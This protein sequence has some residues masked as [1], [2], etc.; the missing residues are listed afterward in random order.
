MKGDRAQP[1]GLFPAK[2]PLFQFIKI[3]RF[4]LGKFSGRSERV[5]ATTS[6]G[7]SQRNQTTVRMALDAGRIAR[8][9]PQPQPR[10]QLTH[11]SSVHH[12]KYDVCADINKCA[13]GAARPVGHDPKHHKGKSR[14]SGKL[15]RISFH[16]CY[17]TNGYSLNLRAF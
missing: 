14:Q 1:S 16:H 6:P 15:H 4:F 13:L 8:P 7:P 11:Q 9:W 12:C 17:T 10:P 2:S 3:G 5:R